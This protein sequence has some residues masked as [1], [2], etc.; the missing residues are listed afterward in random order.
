VL[1]PKLE[2][3]VNRV[4]RLDEII[5]FARSRVQLKILLFLSSRPYA[6]LTEISS[7][8]GERRRTISDALLKLRNKGLVE[9]VAR[10]RGIYR[11]SRDGVTFV[12]NLFGLVQMG[13]ADFRKTGLKDKAA[14]DQRP[15]ALANTLISHV[16]LYRIITVVGSSRENVVSLNKLAS[17]LDLSPAVTRSYI[18]KFKEFFIVESTKRRLFFRRKKYHTVAIRL[19]RK[20]RKVYNALLQNTRG[21]LYFVFNRFFRKHVLILYM[22]LFLSAILTVTSCNVFSLATL[23]IATVSILYYRQ[24]YII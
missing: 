9:R 4:C 7:A 24:K 1:Q 2:D 15:R 8:L 11:L 21:Q 18:D 23:I 16:I 19:S 10:Q 12:E 13:Y 6:S 17:F 22:F 14:N 20:G 5:D 3:F